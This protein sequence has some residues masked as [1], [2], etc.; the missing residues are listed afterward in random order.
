[1]V[2]SA[3]RDTNSFLYFFKMFP[4]IIKKISLLFFLNAS[5]DFKIPLLAR[6]PSC[7]RL[8]SIG[9]FDLGFG[10]SLNSSCTNSRSIGCFGL[11]F[12]SS[13]T[14]SLP[15]VAKNNNYRLKG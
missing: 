5:K 9:G 8:R 4:E 2:P 15:P 6:N 13:M 7:T 11:V 12:G 14:S 3:S 1:M 10:S